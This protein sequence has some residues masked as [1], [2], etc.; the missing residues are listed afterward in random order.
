MSSIFQIGQKY[1]EV[2]D[3]C[4]KLAEAVE[5][6][7]MEADESSVLYEP[8]LDALRNSG[9]SSLMVPEAYGGRFGEID[10][11]LLYT[12]DAADE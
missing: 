3:D 5:P 6:F 9:L 2:I 8:V 4:E 7:A 11:C 12:S 1:Q 10:P